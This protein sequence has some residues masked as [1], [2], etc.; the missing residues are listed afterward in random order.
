[1]R[2]PAFSISDKVNEKEHLRIYKEN[3]SLWGNENTGL[4]T[5]LQFI[6]DREDNV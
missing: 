5:I 6:V 3:L 4:L 1:M 2:N